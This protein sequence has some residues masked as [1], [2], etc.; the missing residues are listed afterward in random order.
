[1]N[2]AAENIVN[3]IAKIEEEDIIFIHGK[4]YL[5]RPVE[6]DDLKIVIKNNRCMD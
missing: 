5:I 4:A 2:N 3:L 6:V 1:M